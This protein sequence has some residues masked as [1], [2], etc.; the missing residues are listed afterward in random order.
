[1]AQVVRNRAMET[2]IGQRAEALLRSLGDQ[3]ADAVREEIRRSAPAGRVYR[4][5][6]VRHRASAPGQPPAIFTGRLIGGI[7]ALTRGR[8]FGAESRVGT[9]ADYAAALEFGTSGVAPRPFA[10]PALARLR[11]QGQGAR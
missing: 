6:G 9:D 11:A 5:Q 8:G 10:R 4:I 3:Y 1:M 2:A 7:Q